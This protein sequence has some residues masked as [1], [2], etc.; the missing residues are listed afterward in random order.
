MTR[1]L[2]YG[3]RAL[4]K[5]ARS[6]EI[7][8]GFEL[9]EAIEEPRIVAAFASG[10][11][12][13]ADGRLVFSASAEQ[14]SYL[15][16]PKTRERVALGLLR[17]SGQLDAVQRID[18][19]PDSRLTDL[20]PFAG[21]PA[22]IELHLG[23]VPWAVSVDLSPLVSLPRL[24][25]LTLRRFARLTDLSPLAEIQT[26]RWLDLASCS[27]IEDLSPLAELPALRWLCL[28]GCRGLPG[29]K[30]AIF[31]SRQQVAEVLG[32]EA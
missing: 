25:A 23:N 24:E 30:R 19:G 4:L 6:E 5:S 22:L 20:S 2:I 21:L 7:R 9:L 13:D 18:L 11:S 27:R 1:A 3:A 14:R 16:R 31:A 26:L 17:L 15:R 32:I 10:V 8:Q 28:E 29:E 12:I